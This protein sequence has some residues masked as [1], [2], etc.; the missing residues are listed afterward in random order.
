VES[1][2]PPPWQYTA[3][4]SSK[5]KQHS[6]RGCTRKDIQND[7]GEENWPGQITGIVLLGWRWRIEC[8]GGKRI[9]LKTD[10]V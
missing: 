4:G 5:I 1:A 8:G 2:T 6:S 3:E 7:G 10:S 9:N